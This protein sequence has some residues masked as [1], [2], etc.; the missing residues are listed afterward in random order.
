MKKSIQRIGCIVFVLALI[1]M[2]FMVSG[3]GQSGDAKITSKWKISEM[4]VNG[5][6][7]READY[8]P[9]VRLFTSKDA[10][11]F[12]VSKDGA[13]CVLTIGQKN[14]KGTVTEEDG[15]YIIDFDDSYSNMIGEISGNKLS[16]TNEK[17][18]VL[19]LFETK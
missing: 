15:K 13:S 2:V 11:K 16:L 1:G 3:C 14:H 7:T 18:T 12:K 8:S 5:K 6:V 17:G 10:P 9:I 4:M 19:L